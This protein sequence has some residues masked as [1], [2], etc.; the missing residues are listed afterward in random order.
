MLPW[1]R[2]AVIY[3]VTSP[4]AKCQMR[5]VPTRPHIMIIIIA[6]IACTLCYGHFWCRCMRAERGT[7]N[8]I[9]SFTNHKGAFIA[10]GKSFHM[11]WHLAFLWSVCVISFNGNSHS[12]ARAL[13]HAQAYSTSQAWRWRA[14]NRMRAARTM[15]SHSIQM[16]HIAMYISANP[17]FVYNQ[18]N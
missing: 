17:A 10:F 5:C 8:L 2:L 7:L 18:R 12:C 4:F 1:P 3:C 13:S 14:E 6:Y 15:A 11:W 9:K 16:R